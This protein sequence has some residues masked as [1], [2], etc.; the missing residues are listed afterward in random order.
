MPYQIITK[1]HTYVQYKICD[2]FG[3][4]VWEV[5]D[6]RTDAG[7]ERFIQIFGYPRVSKRRKS[8]QILLRNGQHQLPEYF[9]PEAQS[10]PRRLQRAPYDKHYNPAP[11]EVVGSIT[12]PFTEQQAIKAA[13]G[14]EGHL[15]HL[16]LANNLDYFVTRQ[17]QEKRRIFSQNCQWDDIIRLELARIRLGI[18]KIQTF[19][20]FLED[21]DE[22]RLE[23]G[24]ETK[25]IPSNAH[26]YRCLV[27]IGA[28]GVYDWFH[29]LREECEQYQLYDAHLDMWDGRFLSSYS[30]GYKAQSTGQVSDPAVGKYVHQKKFLGI[31]YL[32]SRIIN[33]R[34]RLPKYYTLV[35]PQQ[36]D[37]QT[38]QQ[39]F[40]EM[41][42]A[43]ID[44]AEIILADGGP[45]AHKSSELV[46]DYGS[47]PIIAAPKNAAGLVLLTPKERRFY[48]RHIPDKYWSILDDLFDKRTRVEQSFGHDQERYALNK[49]P[50]L[51]L[52]LSHQFIG[53]VNCEALLTALTAVKTAQFHL[54]SRPGSF[55]RLGLAY[56]D[57]T[58]AHILQL[59]DPPA[60]LQ[61]R[62]GHV[63]NQ[64]KRSTAYDMSLTSPEVKWANKIV[65]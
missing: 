3:E 49:I 60:N 6:C 5:I 10:L 54:V 8:N 24:L 17:H 64:L 16:F 32:E 44:P 39:T 63:S 2:F 18:P 20:T 59:Q 37:N 22:L 57:L 19:L 9:D 35:N 29:Q 43:G 55:R 34:F 52:E 28:T 41:I 46:R 42:R 30:S 38:F 14:F 45:K 27:D 62:S 4:V 36:N 23:C 33:S 7:Q 48:A 50:H 13:N 21:W 1:Q 31:G 11:S 40:R 47:T 61:D 58:L 15:Y 51:G 12:L 56:Q 26:Y 25:T 65:I 53:L